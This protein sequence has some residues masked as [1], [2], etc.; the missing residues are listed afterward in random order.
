MRCRLPDDRDP[1]LRSSPYFSASVRPA[2]PLRSLSAHPSRG[3]IPPACLR[4]CF[5][6][7]KRRHEGVTTRPDRNAPGASYLSD[8]CRCFAGAHAPPPPRGVHVRQPAFSSLRRQPIIVS[9]SSL[10]SVF[11]NQ[12]IMMRQAA[13]SVRA[14]TALESRL[15]AADCITRLTSPAQAD[16]AAPSHDGMHA[17]CFATPA[18]FRVHYALPLAEHQ[19][20]ADIAAALPASWR[21]LSLAYRSEQC[22]ARS[23]AGTG[24]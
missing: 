9:V 24:L 11:L 23:C 21:R 20:T 14:L 22:R 13:L 10:Q 17:R 7:Q 5:E 4:A 18:A 15:W 8:A 1:C 6:Q 16:A 12:P 2:L 19:H 3:P